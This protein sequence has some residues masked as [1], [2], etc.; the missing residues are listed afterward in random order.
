[1][2]ERVCVI[3]VILSF[4]FLLACLWFPKI[5]YSEESKLGEKKS[6]ESRVDEL[7]REFPKPMEGDE[8][9]EDLK[10]FFK[11]KA[12]EYKMVKGQLHRSTEKTV[13]VYEE[14]RDLI[15][16]ESTCCDYE[17]VSESD[18]KFPYIV[19]VTFQEFKGGERSCQGKVKIQQI[20]G[21]GGLASEV[22]YTYITLT[23]NY[24]TFKF[25]KGPVS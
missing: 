23:P 2:K 10:L 7:F 1:M 19:Y 14:L 13:Y 16:A 4:G 3:A 20:H 5:S 24:I 21:H 22:D 9:S 17:F 8:A 18:N 6:M 11:A 25:E 12:L 15:P